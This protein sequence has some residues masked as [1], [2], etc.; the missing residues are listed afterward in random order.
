MTVNVMLNSMSE[1]EY[2]NWSK[3]IT[4]HETPDVQEIQ[5]AVISNLIVSAMGSKKKTTYK[6]F[7]LRG[8]TKKKEPISSDA[9]KAIFATLTI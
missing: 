2:T 9:I 8:N 5:L 6:D 1:E 3:Y 7:L 4:K